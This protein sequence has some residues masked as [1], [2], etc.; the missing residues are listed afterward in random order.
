MK[1]AKI[2]NKKGKLVETVEFDVTRTTSGVITL[3]SEEENGSCMKDTVASIP[4]QKFVVV[5]DEIV[6]PEDVQRAT[7]Y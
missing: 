5:I 4:L 7:R 6:S 3:Y 1:Q 2:Y